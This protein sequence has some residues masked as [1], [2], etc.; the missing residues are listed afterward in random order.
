LFLNYD[1]YV[2]AQIKIKDNEVSKKVKTDLGKDL[3]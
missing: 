1:R 2:S 3:A